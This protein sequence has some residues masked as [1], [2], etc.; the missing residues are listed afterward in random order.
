MTEIADAQAVNVVSL[1]TP[2]RIVWESLRGIRASFPGWHVWCTADSATWN[3]H[4][5]GREPFFGPLPDGAPVFMVSASTAA[6]LVALLERQTLGDMTREFPTWRIGRTDSG[7]WYALSHGR[8]GVRLVQG[9]DAAL[10]RETV[11]A[12]IR[13]AGPHRVREATS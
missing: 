12:L 3:A 4:R 13:Y 5:E 9:R 7:N 8:C 6:Q 2:A 10:L 1:P 11:R